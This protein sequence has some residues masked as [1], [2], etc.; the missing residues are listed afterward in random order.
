MCA[1][2]SCATI[3]LVSLN[4]WNS[5]TE[6]STKHNIIIPNILVISC[7]IFRRLIIL[8][9]HFSIKIMCVCKRE[10]FG[11]YEDCRTERTESTKYDM[12]RRKM[13][14][15]E[16][17]LDAPHRNLVCGPNPSENKQNIWKSVEYE[18]E[19]KHTQWETHSPQCSKSVSP[20][21]LF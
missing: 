8:K 1:C 11:S 16:N 19:W 12:C 14:R 2:I 15:M 13:R 9:F 4:L 10:N 7:R 21:L 17:I 20:S 6:I 5:K 3:L 18:I